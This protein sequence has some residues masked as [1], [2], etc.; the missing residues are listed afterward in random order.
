M[1]PTWD[2]PTRLVHWLLLSALLLSWLSHEFEWYQVHLWSGYSV[3][4]VVVFRLLWGVFGSA[5]SRFSD[6]LSGPVTLLRYWRGELGERTGHNPVGGWSVLL[7]LLLILFQAL[8]GLFNSDGLLFDGP[9]YHA[10]DS[11]WTDKLGEL[12]EQLFWVILALV[13]LH[14]L[15]VL[16]YQFVRGDDLLQPMIQGG[17]E[18]S[19]AP[20]S[21]WRALLLLLLCVSGLALAVYLAPEPEI[22]W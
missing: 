3:L 6:F 1:H 13:V 12:H 10:L 16:Y 21:T 14:V 17:A 4:V 5:H 8:T 19:S 18:G 11:A 20:V 2:L 7:M 22:Y 9:L 15:A